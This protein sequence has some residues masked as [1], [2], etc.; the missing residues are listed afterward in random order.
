MPTDASRK[1]RGGGCEPCSFMEIV[2]H[3]VVKFWSYSPR[4]SKRA[5][6]VMRL[7][8]VVMHA[9]AEKTRQHGFS[10]HHRQGSL[11]AGKRH[12]NRRPV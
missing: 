7:G 5:S 1:R 12:V 2:I 3:L 10:R 4:S 6:M 8:D 11:G 9:A